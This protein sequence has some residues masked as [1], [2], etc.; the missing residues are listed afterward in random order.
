VAL[1]CRLLGNAS[2]ILRLQYG[3]L[4]CGFPPT[5]GAA[6]AVNGLARVND[7]HAGGTSSAA[8]GLALGAGQG[9][10]PIDFRGMVSL[11]A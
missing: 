1:S 8:A 11:R 5:L 2:S 3:H 4:G 10:S 6:A 7:R 9:V